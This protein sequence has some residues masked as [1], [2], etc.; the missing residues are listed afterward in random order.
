MRRFPPYQRRQRQAERQFYE[1][2][3]KG[4]GRREHR[5][6]ETT[7][8]LNH[9]LQQHLG[10]SSVQQVFR[11]TRAR[12]RPHPLTGQ[13]ERSTEVAYG[14]TSL[15]RKQ[16]DAKQLLAYNRGHW[17]IENGLHY[18][19]DVTFGEDQSRLR[20]GHGPQHLAAARNTTIAL[21][22]RNNY[23]NLAE[24]RRDFAWNPQ[25][26]FTILGDFTN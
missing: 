14:I 11:I 6:I 5:T 21:C 20:K 19:R 16:A 4:H 25:P 9:F 7:T 15:S 3:D 2:G 26:L 17:G 23:S 12:F 1:E 13:W 22:R 18:V 24:A 10:W 8:A